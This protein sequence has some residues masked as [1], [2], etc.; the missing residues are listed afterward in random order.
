MGYIIFG[1]GGHGK[2]VLDN[3]H[4]CG[5][6]VIG[7]MDDHLRGSDWRGIP[8][9]GGLDRLKKIDLMYPQSL[10]II[11]IGHNATRVKLANIF[12]QSNVQFGKAIHSTAIIGSNVVIG[13]GAVIMANTV[14]NAD[15]HIGRH[16]IVNTAATVDHDCFIGDFVHL[17]PGVHLAG[18]VEIGC[19]AHVGIGASIVPQVKVGRGTIVG[20][21]AAVI[22]SLPE[23]VV[24]VGCPAKINKHFKSKG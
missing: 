23:Q 7:I 16:V 3:L 14:I 2:V 12:E 8:L 22:Q 11:A 21:G 1:A 6:K 4:S 20:A 10:Y 13:D 9:L 24:A 15:A 5:E 18:G 17:S 19:S